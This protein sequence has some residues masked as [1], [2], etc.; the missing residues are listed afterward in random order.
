MKNFFNDVVTVA[1]LVNENNGMQ[2]YDV[3]VEIVDRDEINFVLDEK[4]GS[5]EYD[6]GMWLEVYNKDGY[7]VGF[8]LDE[9][10]I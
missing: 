6:D 5:V 7:V 4:I 1:V 8:W 9:D 10:E 2:S 3:D